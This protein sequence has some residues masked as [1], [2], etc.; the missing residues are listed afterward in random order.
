MHNLF[1]SIRVYDENSFV[2]KTFQFFLTYFNFRLFVRS[3]CT[4]KATSSISNSFWL[5]LL[6]FSS[7]TNFFELNDPKIEKHYKWTLKRL[8]VSMVSTF[9]PHSMCKKIERVTAKT[10]C[11]SCTKR[12]ISFKVSGFH[13]ETRLLQRDFIF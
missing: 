6:I 7:F 9:H 11:T 12:T 5:H 3:V 10:G 8:K 4:L 1:R 2:R 13:T